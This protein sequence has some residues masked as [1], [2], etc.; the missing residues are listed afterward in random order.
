[1]VELLGDDVDKGEKQV[2]KTNVDHTY[3]KRLR[4]IFKALLQEDCDDVEM[5]EKWDHTFHIY[6][7]Y[8]MGIIL[9]TDK[10]A[11]GVDVWYLLYLRDMELVSNYAWREAALTHL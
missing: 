10:S 6:L 7:L 2:W 8:L 5:K 1:M 4:E 3:F 9:F 11:T